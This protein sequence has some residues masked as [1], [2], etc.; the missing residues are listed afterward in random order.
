MAGRKFQ[1]VKTNINMAKKYSE[2]IQR[3]VYMN[4]ETGIKYAIDISEVLI[5]QKHYRDMDHF[6]YAPDNLF[7]DG[8]LFSSN[9]K[10]WML[11]LDY[12]HKAKR[13]I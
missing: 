6:L 9:R 3:V 2:D 10:N 1:G 5:M 12:E 11:I 13:K 8:C 4:P 7:V